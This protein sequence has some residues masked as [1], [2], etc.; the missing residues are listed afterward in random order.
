MQAFIDQTRVS[1]RMNKDMIATLIRWSG[2]NSHSENLTGL[3]QMLSELEISMGALQGI[4]RRLPLP[5]RIHINWQNETIESPACDALHIQKRPEAPVQILL[6][7]HFDTV[8][9]AECPFQEAKFLDDKRLGGPGVA[10]MKGGLLI[11]LNSLMLIEQ[12]ASASKIGW[13]ILLTPD[14]EIGS[15]G[16]GKLYSEAA[17]HAHYGFLFE[18]AFPDGSFVS[19]RKGSA[20]FT[21]VAKGKAAHAG[22]DFHQGRNAIVALAHFI[23]SAHEL[24][25]QHSGFSLNIGQIKGGEAPNIV[26]EFACC[27]INIRADDEND[28]ALAAKSL[29]TLVAKVSDHFPKECEGI[30]L[31]VLPLG[32]RSPK[33]FDLKTQHL[34]TLVHQCGEHLGLDLSWKKSGGVCDGNILA[35]AGLT[36]IDTLGAVGGHLHTYN[37]Y[38]ELSSLA[39]RTQLT[40]LVLLSIASNHEL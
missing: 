23:I 13:Q 22:R 19:Q 9:S 31:Q 37:E 2:I 7:G 33:P 26:P 40:A 6:G 14:E 38:I 30:V 17:K 8:F 15:P 32:S 24:N 39:E 16:S 10:D 5:K 18:P 12:S 25:H 34:F 29:Q 1:D 11:L 35:E 21:I 28:L 20:H 4:T 36:T 27:S 3:N